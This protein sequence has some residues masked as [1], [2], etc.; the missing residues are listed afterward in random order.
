MGE[1]LRDAVAGREGVG[2]AEHHEDPMGRAG[3]QPESRL[4]DDHAGAL[5]ANQ[6]AGHVKAVLGEQLVQVV[7]RHPPGDPRVALPDETGVA[8]SEGRHPGVD[9]PPPP[10]PR[11]DVL[12][13]AVAGA[14][15]PQAQ[16]VVGEHLELLHVVGGPPR[17]E[18][19]EA[20]GVVADH[21]PEGATVMRGRV[22]TEGEAVARRGG[23]QLVEDDAR[24]DPGEPALR[25]DPDDAAQVLGGVDDHGGVAG[26]A[27]Q[28][29]P[30]APGEHGRPVAPAGLQGGL[31]VASVPGEHHAG[32]HLTVVRGVGGVEGPAPGIEADLPPDASPELGGEERGIARRPSPIRAHRRSL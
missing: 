17:H 32:G 14:S 25:V 11:H 6:G 22:G 30:R 26:L 18:R 31:D 2:V 5:R 28:A 8:V 3:D 9:L 13:L 24:L 10:A 1:H 27:G 23:S 19:V 4:Q 7:A 29:G 12:Q 21:P 16:A 20:A 15:H